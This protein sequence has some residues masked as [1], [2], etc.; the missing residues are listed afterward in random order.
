VILTRLDRAEEHAPP[1][2]LDP[3]PPSGVVTPPLDEPP[4]P[5]DP[6]ELEPELA[7]ELPLE[8]PP[9]D[10]LPPE[11]VP[12]ELVPPE[13]PLLERPESSPLL[14]P[15]GLL[16]VPHPTTRSEQALPTRTL[17]ARRTTRN[18]RVEIRAIMLAPPLGRCP[19]GTLPVKE[20]LGDTEAFLNAARLNFRAT[21]QDEPQRSR[22]ATSGIDPG[23]AASNGFRPGNV[24]IAYFDSSRMYA[25]WYWSLGSVTSQES[26]GQKSLKSAYDFWAGCDAGGE[27]GLEPQAALF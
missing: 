14:C 16:E 18:D 13:P 21:S 12:P 5:E 17:E 15:A 27:R 26:S 23:E 3:Y 1:S 11:L 7:P 4:S 22:R 10:V 24:H 19:P 25:A 20:K 9:P 2:P 8:P 6:P